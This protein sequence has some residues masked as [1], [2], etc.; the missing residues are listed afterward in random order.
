MRADLIAAMGLTGT[1]LNT[2][3]TFIVRKMSPADIEMSLDVWSKDGLTDQQIIAAVTAKM[4]A[5]RER[6]QSFLPKSVKF[7]DGAI[8]D[9]AKRLNR[10]AGK[11]APTSVGSE[12]PAQRRARRQ[13]MIG[14]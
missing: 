9:H 4:L 12:T 13:R 6:D 1:E 10:P 8:S 2:S 7:F 5:E 3:G 11:D 14:G